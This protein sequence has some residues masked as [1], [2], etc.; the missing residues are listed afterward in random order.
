[1]T[2]VNGVLSGGTYGVDPITWVWAPGGDYASGFGSQYGGDQIMDGIGIS[3]GN[4]TKFTNFITLT[5]DFSGAPNLVLAT[6]GNTLSWLG[7]N[8]VDYNDPFVSGS[9]S[10]ATPEPGSFILLGTGLVGCLGVIRRK[11]AALVP[12]TDING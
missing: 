7:G 3:A 6:P 4:Y 8:S 9:F 2:A 1:L 5:W 10:A 11:F 12:S